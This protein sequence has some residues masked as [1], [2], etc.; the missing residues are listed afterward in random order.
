MCVSHVFVQTEIKLK[1]LL[2]HFQQCRVVVPAG[3]AAVQV[4]PSEPDSHRAP[5]RG[6]YLSRHET[7]GDCRST[8]R[9][10]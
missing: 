3:R 1:D 10:H 5:L 8:T 4:P 2:K 9:R 7:R 6:G